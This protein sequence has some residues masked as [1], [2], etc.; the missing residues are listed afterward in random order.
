[1]NIQPLTVQHL[2]DEKLISPSMA[3][4]VF[5]SDILKQKSRLRREMLIATAYRICEIYAALVHA[6]VVG[7]AIY[8]GTTVD[9]LT[10]KHVAQKILDFWNTNVSKKFNDM[11]PLSFLFDAMRDNDPNWFTLDAE[12]I[13][14]EVRNI[15][16]Q[17]SHGAPSGNKEKKDDPYSITP[18]MLKRL[19]RALP[20]FRTTVVD[21]KN[22]KFVFRDKKD[23]FSIKCMP[24][25]G[26]WNEE[27]KI[28]VGRDTD[29]VNLDEGLPN[30]SYVLVGVK[31]GR[32]EMHLRFEIL[33]LDGRRDDKKQL[34]TTTIQNS[35]NSEYLRMV[36]AAVKHSIEWSPVKQTKCDLSFLKTL[37]EAVS[38]TLISFW[39]SEETYI[40]PGLIT[41]ESHLRKMFMGSELQNA[42]GEN[43][44]IEE[45]DLVNVF[46]ELFINYGIFKTMYALFLDLGNWQYGEKLFDAYFESLKEAVLTEESVLKYKAECDECIE[47]HLKKLITVIPETSPKA[48]KSRKRAIFAE[49]RAYYALKAAGLHADKLFTEQES[50]QSIDD[51]YYMIK[52]SSTQ[53][54]DDLHEVMTMLIGFYEA[55]LSAS[56]PFDEDKFYKDMWSA[57]KNVGNRPL[58][59]L[60]ES[61]KNVVI[62]SEKDNES[63]EQY[64]G[65]NRVCDSTRLEKV[66]APVRKCL[67]MSQTAQGLQ[68]NGKDQIFI[69]YAHDDAK[70]VERYIKSWTD[71]GMPIFQDKNRFKAGDDWL[72]RA[73]EFIHSPDCKVVVVFLSENSVIS[74]AVAEEIEAAAASAANKYTSDI[75]KDRFIIAINLCSE[76]SAQEYLHHRL[77]FDSKNGGFPRNEEGAARR[78]AK[79]ITEY[80]LQTE[81]YDGRDQ[82]L[83]E[84]N[85]RMTVE[86][87]GMLDCDQRK[88]NDLE[89]SVA[90]LYAFLKF[91]DEFQ[92]CRKEEI[93]EIFKTKRVNGK[94]CIFPLVA[95]VKETKIKR[96]NI[97]LMGYEIIGNKESE[98]TTT[99]Y[100]L[101]ADHL[102]QDDYYCL[103]NSRTTA[104]DCSWMVEPFLIRYH[105]FTKPPKENLK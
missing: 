59:E 89:Y 86:C 47:D 69:S 21:E 77:K 10:Y 43:A 104:S 7:K 55:L 46:Y 34:V 79:V 54:T 35:L 65:R 91:G 95:A 26:Y 80:K 67:K 51:Y 8:M 88:Y 81:L 4:I 5:S 57:R 2:I 72:A 64:V 30:E 49:W 56:I 28:A 68:S 12:S 98:T 40:Q 27:K 96:D 14:Y 99:N 75:N 41:V 50:I 36:C 82:I 19:L 22:L 1:M 78:I 3:D 6:Y 44:K 24:F 73:K 37:T 13:L 58:I 63:L 38:R 87:D 16:G 62:R 90:L 70:A 32:D 105:L 18:E 25:V 45:E 33:V 101:S 42:I 83:K 84:I 76:R 94:T 97:T 17:Y 66:L 92:G 74:D 48:L 15:Y 93:D 31:K 61:F 9:A 52:N 11:A 103:P 71:Q 85:D 20:L 53:L 23:V 102:R 100:I 29:Y 60:L 39:N